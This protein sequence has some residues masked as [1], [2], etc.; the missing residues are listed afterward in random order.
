MLRLVVHQFGVLAED[1]VALG[2]RGMLKLE[3]GSRVEQV[4]LA[5]T[6]PL[7]LTAAFELAVGELRRAL[8]VCE[9]MP[10]S[11]LC[12]QHV[13]AH[14]TDPAGCACEILLYHSPV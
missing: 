3:H 12:S 14:P 5:V 2:A 4:E 6:S 8:Q 9:V 10:G 13:E 1:V 11:H 7:V